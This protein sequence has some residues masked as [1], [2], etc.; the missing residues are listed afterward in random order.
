MTRIGK[1]PI[2]IPHGV[3][4]TI[5][6]NEVTV[7]GPKGEL[8]RMF[9]PDMAIKMEDGIV[10]ITRPSDHRNHK[11]LHGLTRSLINNMVMGVSNG[12]TRELAIEGVGYRAQVSGKDL[13]LNVGYS[14]PVVFEGSEHVSFEV[15]RTGREL[16][17]H[18]I[19]KEF[20]G[21]IAARI[22][23]TRPPEPYKGKG[24]RYKGEYVRR[25]DG[26]AGKK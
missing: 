23:R 19:D 15:D 6:R 7:K 13:V 2:P 9:S 20:V 3:A 11:A 22:R 14:H 18:G 8:K 4:V 21:E 25:K 26:K 5:N 1:I 17:V 10:K 12:F 24:I 16:K